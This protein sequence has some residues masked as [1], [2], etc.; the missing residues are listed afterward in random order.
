MFVQVARCR[1]D[2]H[3]AES[4][5]GVRDKSPDRDKTTKQNITW[6]CAVGWY[7]HQWEPA[8]MIH[9]RNILWQP[10][11][12][13]VRIRAEPEL[14]AECV[15]SAMFISHSFSVSLLESHCL[16]I[17]VQWILAQSSR[18]KKSSTSGMRRGVDLTFFIYIHTMFVR[19]A[20][21]CALCPNYFVCSDTQ[22]PQQYMW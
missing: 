15:A 7:C 1:P 9:T 5:E 16:S 2:T 20:L 14:S 13:C 8:S 3:R 11:W 12:F 10:V 4:S 6:G 21:S 22:S 18:K 17:S 19:R